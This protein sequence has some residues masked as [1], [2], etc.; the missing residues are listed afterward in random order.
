MDLLRITHEDFVLTVDCERFD[1]VW[2]KAV[3]NL[4]KDPLVSTYDWS[5]GVINVNI[6]EHSI[7]CGSKAQAVFFDNTDYPIWVDFAA[8]ITNAW[9]NTPQ[10][11]VAENFKYRRQQHLLAGF[12][13]Y[14]NEIGRSELILNYATD[15]GTIKHFRITFDVLS[16]KLNYHEHW[17]EI[18]RD[19]ETEYRMLSIDFLK[20]T[21]HSFEI[22]DLTEP[23]HD[24]IWWQV[25][26]PLRIDFINAVKDILQRPRHRLM[27]KEE[28]IRADR[29]KHWTPALENEYERFKEN[30]RH[31]YRTE[32][33][34][35]S[36]DT[37]ENRFLKHAVATI[38]QKHAA[39]GNSILQSSDISAPWRNEIANAVN[40][41]NAI[42]RHSFFR[43]IGPWHGSSQESLILQRDSHYS[44]VYRTWLILQQSYALNEGL[45]ALETKDIAT[46]YEIWC[47]IQVKNIIKQQL[48]D[49]IEI[50]NYSRVE[51]NQFFHNSLGIGDHSRILF[52]NGNVE[53]AELIYN[54]KHTDTDTSTINIDNLI[55]ATVPQKPDIVLRLT[56][57]DTEKDIKLTYL[58]DA[59][60]RIGGRIN[61]VDVPPDDAINQMHRYRDAIYYDEHNNNGLKKEVVGGYILFPGSGNILQP[62]LAKFYNSISKV[63]IGAFPLRPLETENRR[64]LELFI[65]NLLHQNAESL[66][67]NRNIVPQKG[68]K[69]ETDEADLGENPL[70]LIGYVKKDTLPDVKRLRKYYVRIGKRRG[71]LKL[72]PEFFNAK[73]LIL[74]QGNRSEE[75]LMFEFDDNPPKIYSGEDLD[76][77]G[78]SVEQQNMNNI[79]LCYIL[80]SGEPIAIIEN[81]LDRPV[82]EPDIYSPYFLP[83]YNCI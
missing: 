59:K 3:S 66:L 41:L 1:S 15:D 6:N 29:I 8:N 9:L 18:V 78:F 28:F 14:G 22:S 12:I 68:L 48:G 49:D 62:Q 79:Y 45:H 10:R 23:T 2:H 53:L 4:T 34:A 58:F 42:P 17:R 16:S 75:K 64:V 31:S 67:K 71:S 56:K 27:N 7:A 83:L 55:S 60:Y 5:E 80:N 25:F 46:L 44:T 72:I 69:Y 70:C 74:H 21:F 50:E 26:K 43:T 37:Y 77:I 35:M 63:N 11:K 82:S 52:R 57:K 40:D 47:Y 19:I 38:A 76:A 54:P 13:N 81:K 61:G 20:K 36:H 39:L 24:L 51:M 33:S 30:C 73:Y 32:V 65:N